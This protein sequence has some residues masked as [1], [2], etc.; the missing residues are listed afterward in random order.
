VYT[1]AADYN[2]WE[3][4]E[5][6]TLVIQELL[7]NT[8]LGCFW[9]VDMRR[10]FLPFVGATDAS[11]VFGHGAAV[12]PL[13]VDAVQRLGRECQKKGAQF[14]FEEESE[15]LRDSARCQLGYK[16][17][18]VVLSVRVQDPEHI[19]IE[20]A[21]A[22]L[23]F[24]QWILR[25]RDRFQKHLV[26]LLDS[27]VVIGAVVKGRSSSVP[28]NRLLRRLCAL[29]CAG[30]LTLHL[31]YV[32]SA[33][34][35]SDPPSRG[36]PATW[37]PELRRSTRHGVKGGLRARRRADRRAEVLR[38]RAEQKYKK[39]MASPLFEK[40]RSL[41]KAWERLKETRM[42]LSS[43]SDAGSLSSS[44]GILTSSSVS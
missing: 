18:E 34:N 39:T 35:L 16:D 38:H 40:I 44:L 36:G 24:V 10:P 32:E 20:E 4:T 14:T 28:L 2:D 37:P 31:M 33:K 17:F 43:D 29:T 21:Q 15:R 42:I 26:V 8:M 27:R 11:T 5:L 22:L 1:F 25:S 3:I 7:M 6:P 23:R 9:G 30:G 12:A 41:G 13:S 19:N